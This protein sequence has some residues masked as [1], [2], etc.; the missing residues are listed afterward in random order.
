MVT[1]VPVLSPRRWAANGLS[2]HGDARKR[3]IEA[4][5]SIH[6]GSV[7]VSQRQVGCRQAIHQVLEW[8]LFWVR[9]FDV[10]RAAAAWGSSEPSGRRSKVYENVKETKRVDPP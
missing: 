2:R 3:Y 10:G 9:G 8:C 1:G 5:E 7:P 4:P 6:L